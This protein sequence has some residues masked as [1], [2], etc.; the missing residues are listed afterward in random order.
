MAKKQNTSVRSGA[1]T[2]PS[3]SGASRSPAR[4]R[5]AAAQRAIANDSSNPVAAPTHTEI[6]TVAYQRF[7]DRGCVDGYDIEDWVEA[8]RELLRRSR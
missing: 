2:S 4:G 1:N 5:A 6:A 8:E 3:S 7:L